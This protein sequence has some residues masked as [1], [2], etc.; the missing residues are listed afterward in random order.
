[1]EAAAAGFGSAPLSGPGADRARDDDAFQG[2]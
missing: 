1:M 2:L